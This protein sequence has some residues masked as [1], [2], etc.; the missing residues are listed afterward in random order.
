MLQFLD[1]TNLYFCAYY[2][3]KTEHVQFYYASLTPRVFLV[4]HYLKLSTVFG[5]IIILPIFLSLAY[6]V[7]PPPCLLFPLLDQAL[8]TVFY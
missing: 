1:P 8:K 3:I 4:S 7:I 5:I 2:T 6:S